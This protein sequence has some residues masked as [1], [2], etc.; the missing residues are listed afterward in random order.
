MSRA[1]D[2]ADFNASLFADD[3][4]SGDK[5]SGGTIG[6]GTFNGT[7][8]SNATFSANQ[9]VQIVTSTSSSG[10]STTNAQTLQRDTN[11]SAQITNV[12]SG[13]YVLIFS[14]F[15]A[16]TGTQSTTQNQAS[17]GFG[18]FREASAIF[19]SQSDAYY[20][21]PQSGSAVYGKLPISY[22][23]LDTSP[24]TGT[25]TYY[26]GLYT[27]ITGYYS[28]IIGSTTRVLTLIEIAQ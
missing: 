20:M 19:T 12:Q 23:A 8:G 24:A 15:V 4:I 5:V 18:L 14:S 13:N 17:V 16:D 10:S 7:I 9:V 25:N 2:I 21:N 1:R 6:A 26:Q 27:H 22:Q 3:E 11:F 28:Y